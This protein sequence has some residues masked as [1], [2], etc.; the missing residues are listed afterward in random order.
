MLRGRSACDA[1]VPNA[2]QTA[3]N[4]SSALNVIEA[5]SVDRPAA[6][7]RSRRLLPASVGSFGKAGKYYF[8]SEY[9]ARLSQPKG[10][11]FDENGSRGSS[12]KSTMTFL[13]VR[14]S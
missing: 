7:F 3:A 6:S 9:A 14:N 1:T 4:A 5:P 8:D 12:E 10:Y 2:S 13:V 11:I